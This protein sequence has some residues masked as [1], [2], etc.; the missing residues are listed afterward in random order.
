[1]L[2]VT[3]VFQFGGGAGVYLVFSEYKLIFEIF[4][5]EFSLV[6]GYSTYY[7]DYKFK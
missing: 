5:W 6:L 1:M 7:Y 4:N 2:I 3:I